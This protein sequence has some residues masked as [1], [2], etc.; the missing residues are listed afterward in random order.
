M[1]YQVFIDGQSG[2]TGLHL[3]ERLANRKDITL[4]HI[5]E[6]ERKDIHR[7]Q[8][9]INAADI[10]FLCLPDA[11]A[12]E[13]VKLCNNEKTIIIDASTAHKMCIRDRLYC[14]PCRHIY[15]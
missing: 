11:A 5:A 9:L 3:Q 13:A 8:E 14:D 4:L 10:V 7:R 2:T 1:T 6:A 15:A 12:I